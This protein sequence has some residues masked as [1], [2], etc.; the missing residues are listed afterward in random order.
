MSFWKN[1]PLI[2]TIILLIV[3]VV[4]LFST[5]NGTSSG[6]QSIFGQAVAPIQQAL[7][8]ATNG[9]GAWFD[10]VFAQGDTEKENAE[11]RA[12]VAEL[13]S[14]LL[15][16]DRTTKRKRKIKELLNVKDLTEDMPTLTAKVI[17]KSPG[18]WVNTFTINVGSDDGIEAFMVVLTD[19]GLVGRV[20]EVAPTYSKVMTIL[21]SRSGVPALVER[22]RDSGVVKGNTTSMGDSGKLLTLEYTGSDT[23]LMPGDTLI[24]SGLGGLYPKGLPIGEVTEVGRETEGG[25]QVAYVTSQVDFDRLEEVVVITK[26]YEAVE[27]E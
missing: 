5:A 7:Y 20:T 24:T 21:D 13:E 9:I 10:R 17:G 27:E 4:L 3:L 1:K 16:Y 2:I 23:D 26:V 12:Q 6:A 18:Q 8:S 22:T 15:D 19:K 11:L 14:Q 25:E